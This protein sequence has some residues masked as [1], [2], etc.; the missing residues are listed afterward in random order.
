MKATDEIMILRDMVCAGWRTQIIHEGVQSGLFEILS[1][2]PR[3]VDEIAGESGLHGPTVF[4]V[5]K[6]LSSLSLCKYAPPASFSLTSMG[7]LLQAGS[8]QSQRGHA[9]NWGGRI[10]ET[11]RTIGQTLQTGEPGFGSGD[12]NAINS[13]SKAAEA[14]NFAMSEQSRPVARLLATKHDFS[15]YSMVMDVGGGY[16]GTLVE[17]LAAYPDLRG[18]VYDL[19]QVEKGARP[20]FEKAGVAERASFIGGSFFEAVATGAD[21]LILKYILHDWADDECG[22][23]LDN[24]R[25]AMETGQ[26]LLVIE[27]IMPEIPGAEHEDVVRADMVMMPINGKERTLAEY[28]R[29]AAASGFAI[30]SVE[31]LLDGCSVMDFEAI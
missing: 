10:M 14:F 20:Y 18:A 5:L 24:C 28:E 29:F 16:G 30:R 4:R 26:H 12:F 1:D 2:T 27:R 9:L 15:G 17:L 22:P 7:R 13:N 31:P 23:I 21:C 6:A 8:N 25:K 19:P 11:L 3:T